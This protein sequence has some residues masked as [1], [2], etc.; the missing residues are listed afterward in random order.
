MVIGA[1]LFLQILEGGVR[2]DEAIVAQNTK[3]AW[4][5][6]GTEPATNNIRSAAAIKIGRLW[7]IKKIEGEWTIAEDNFFLKL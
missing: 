3:S 1:D 4:I 7:E 6:T 2:H 5:L